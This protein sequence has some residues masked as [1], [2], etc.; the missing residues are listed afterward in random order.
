METTNK[1]FNIE[2]VLRNLNA[3]RALQSNHPNPDI[4]RGYSGWG[5]LREAIF[6]PDVYR[7]LKRLVGNDG[8]DSIKSTLKSAY[9]TPTMLVDFIYNVLKKYA[10]SPRRILEPSAGNG[11]FLERMPAA[12]AEES[13]VVTVEMDSLSCSFLRHLCPYAEVRHQ[14]FETFQETGFDWIVGNPP[15]GQSTVEDSEHPDLAAYSIHHYFVAKAMRLLNPGGVLA[16]IAPRYFLDAPRKH[17][18]S[19]IEQEGGSLWRAWRLPD[20]LFDDAKV[21]VDVVFLQKKARQ[22]PTWIPSHE[23]R[24]G[25]KK[26]FMNQYF[27]DHPECVLGDIEF[28]EIY[29]RWEIKCVNRSD[30]APN[31]ADILAGLPPKK[32]GKPRREHS[33][34][35]QKLDDMRQHIEQLMV[36]IQQLSAQLR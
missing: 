15:F 17:V 28:F 30:I 1:P 13:E 14:G 29:G 25:P 19:I 26:A 24:D 34:I 7:E 4:L 12:I 31:L 27:F 21:S 33:K 20:N 5:G 9:Y 36:N 32:G 23:V 6:C 22:N 35:E 11:V 2:R 18:R 10:P 3:L 8:V 16:M